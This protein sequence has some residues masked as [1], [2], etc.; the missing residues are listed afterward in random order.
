MK[1]LIAA[2][3]VIVG[4]FW[5]YLASAV[6]ALVIA[7]VLGFMLDPFLAIINVPCLMERFSGLGF[8]DRFILVF[9]VRLIIGVLIPIRA[10]T[11]N[12]GGK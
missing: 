3:F 2:V 9:T 12:R 7:F 8:G 5:A 11:E 1:G 10:N 4:M 6:F